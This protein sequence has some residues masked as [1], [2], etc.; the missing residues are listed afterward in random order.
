VVNIAMPDKA[1][2]F[3]FLFFFLSTLTAILANKD[4]YI[5]L[6][7]N[8]SKYMYVC[9]LFCAAGPAVP[10]AVVKQVAKGVDLDAVGSINGVPVYE[11]DMETLKVEDKPW[12]KPG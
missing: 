4:V 1:V 2:L 9:G 8:S 11:F 12:R 7:L 3:L 6:G 10:G 5:N